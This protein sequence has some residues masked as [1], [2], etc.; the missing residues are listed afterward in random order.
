MKRSLVAVILILCAMVVCGAALLTWGLM[1]AADDPGPVLLTW[2]LMGAG[3]DIRHS[4]SG[5]IGSVSVGISE[6][7]VEAALVALVVL[8]ILGGHRLLQRLLSRL[9]TPDDL[10][11]E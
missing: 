1:V 4:G 7:Y 5:G 10:N 9:P 2:A 3:H 8:A 6:F 11:R